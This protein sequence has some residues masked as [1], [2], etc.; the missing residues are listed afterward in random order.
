MDLRIVLMLLAVATL[1]ITGLV[2]AIS[3]LTLHAY[4]EAFLVLCV[5]G[6]IM[7]GLTSDAPEPRP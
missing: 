4:F 2:F 7:Y 6:A 5:L 1:G 3:L